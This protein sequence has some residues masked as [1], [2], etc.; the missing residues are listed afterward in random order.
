MVA[1]RFCAEA[2]LTVPVHLPRFA[3]Q[4]A[5]TTV[6]GPTAL[7][8]CQDALRWIIPP[9]LGLAVAPVNQDVG[10][11]PSRAEDHPLDAWTSER[12][13]S[14]G[15][16]TPCSSTGIGDS[17]PGRQN[18]SF[19]PESGFPERHLHWG[20]TGLLRAHRRLL[21]PPNG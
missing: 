9:K 10:T 21:V 18:G 1:K 4:A 3:E 15:P 20:N 16:V 14:G 19:E 8:V 6:L 12:Q 2:S 13:R 17:L 11:G 7:V 5:R